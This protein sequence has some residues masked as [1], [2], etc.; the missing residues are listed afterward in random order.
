[1]NGYLETVAADDSGC[2]GHLLLEVFTCGQRRSLH[3]LVLE[4]KKCPPLIRET[5][6]YWKYLSPRINLTSNL[7]LFIKHILSGEIKCD[8]MFRNNSQV[9]LD[10]LLLEWGFRLLRISSKQ[11]EIKEL[12]YFLIMLD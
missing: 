2:W 7:L 6:L 1:M 9:Y 10:T 5:S 11:L 12:F 3:M 4:I 8:T